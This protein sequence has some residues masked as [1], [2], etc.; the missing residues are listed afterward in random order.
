MRRRGGGGCVSHRWKLV[1]TSIEC[2]LGYYSTNL[3]V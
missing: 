2:P 3:F 1:K